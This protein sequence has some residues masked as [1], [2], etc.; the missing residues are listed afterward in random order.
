MKNDFE[1][2]ERGALISVGS[3]S[4]PKRESKIYIMNKKGNEECGMEYDKGSV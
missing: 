4:N 3:W 2:V 1:R